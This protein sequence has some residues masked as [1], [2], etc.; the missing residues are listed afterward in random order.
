MKR[1]CHQLMQRA[2]Y[3]FTRRRYDSPMP[4]GVIIKPTDDDKLTIQIRYSGCDFDLRMP[5]YQQVPYDPAL[6][7]V[8]LIESMRYGRIRVLSLDDEGEVIDSRD[9]R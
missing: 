7:V 3:W 8:E 5:K 4:V 9:Y 1:L 2:L 6:Y